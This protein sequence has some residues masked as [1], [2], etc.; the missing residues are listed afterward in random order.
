MD[1]GLSS[2]YRRAGLGP[3]VLTT[4]VGAPLLLAGAWAGGWWWTGMVSAIALL[5]AQEYARL[6]PGIAPLARSA[7]VAVPPLLTL[8][9]GW[10]PD[11]GEGALVVAAAGV[12]VLGVAPWT[13]AGLQPTGWRLTS[14][15]SVLLGAS[16][17]TLL[18]ALVAWRARWDFAVL[19][20]LLLVVWSADIAAYFVGIAIGRHKLAPQ[21]SPGKSWEGFGA[22]ASTAALAGAVASPLAA[23]PPAFAGMTGMAVAVAAVLGDLFESALKRR[24]G[25]KD[26]GVL[27]PGHG[28]VLDRFDGLLFAAPVAYLIFRL[29]ARV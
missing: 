23:L 10:R 5:G 28:G 27:L 26:S 9:T 13:A 14:A 6:L 20:W 7:V 18:A 3:R 22:A 8:A 1:A 17:L 12:L 15:G 29:F 16:Y 2:A 4:V 11:A 19:A 21:V 24:A 25:V